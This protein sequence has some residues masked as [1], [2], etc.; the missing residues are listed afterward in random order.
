MRCAV[1]AAAFAA[2]IWMI[3]PQAAA[4][5]T[6]E[7]AAAPPPT[8]TTAEY[9]YRIKW[10]SAIEFAELYEKNHKPLLEEAKN[11]GFI[12]SMKTDYPFTHMAGGPRWDMRVTIVYRDAAA[13]INDPDLNALWEEA[14]KRLY[15]DKKK[16]D[17]EEARRFSLLEDHW[18]VILMPNQ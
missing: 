2:A 4:Q 13:A 1:I 7:E 15:K 12:V 18:D 6:G 5:E 17:A 11:A 3:P 10:G 14:T 8:H 16:F 9:Y